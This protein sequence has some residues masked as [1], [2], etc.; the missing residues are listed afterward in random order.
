[1][2]GPL[3]DRAALVP[4][5]RQAVLEQQAQP[6]MTSA[7]PKEGHPLA[8]AVYLGGLGADVG[9]TAYG[10]ATGK[11]EE[12]NPLMKVFGNT[13][14]AP[15][16]AGTS[17]AGALLAQKFLR[18]NHPRLL[19]AV[20]L[21]MGGAHGAAALSNLHQMGRS[22]ADSMIGPSGPPRPGMQQAPDGSWYDPNFMTPMGGR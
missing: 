19:K 10:A 7:K 15:L 13:G 11:T 18:K 9:T 14:A 2:P 4:Y 12:A 17:I 1:M 8:T 20:L 22:G 6:A 5:V 21:G 3:F 16:V